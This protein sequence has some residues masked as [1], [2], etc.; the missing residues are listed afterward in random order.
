MS[1][2]ENIS[3]E[4]DL[5]GKTVEGSVTNITNF[6][7]FVSIE[8]SEE[9]L[10]HISEIANEF[11]TDIADFVSVGDKVKV[12]ILARN[13]KKKLELSI[14]QADGTAAV[15]P[16]KKIEKRDKPKQKNFDFEDKLTSFLKRSEERQ[17]DIRRNLKNKQGLTKR[18]TK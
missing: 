1:S 12:K 4:E 5:I 2:D 16:P 10:V 15:R 14:K 11:I 3:A 9:G 13:Q 18:K 8:G 6:G 7:A 17:I